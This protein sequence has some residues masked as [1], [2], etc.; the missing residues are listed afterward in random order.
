MNIKINVKEII[1][2]AIKNLNIDCDYND[3]V[4]EVPK[5]RQNGDFSCVIA[6]KLAKTLKQN[7]RQIAEE[8]KGKILNYN[9][10]EKV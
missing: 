2:E 7:P 4:I 10:I 8:I 3:I 9:E 1:Y 5:L 6:M